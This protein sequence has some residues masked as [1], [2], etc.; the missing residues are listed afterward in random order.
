MFQYR[1]NALSNRRIDPSPANIIDL[2]ILTKEYETSYR[3]WAL[4]NNGTATEPA[5]PTSEELRLQFETLENYKSVSDALIYNSAK[6]KPLFGTAASPE[7]RATFKVIKNPAVNLSDSEI[8]TQVLRYINLFF[9]EGN[10]DFGDTFYFTEL[11]T[12]IQQ[13]L[14]PNISSIVIVPAGT[15][16]I[17]GSLH[18]IGSESDEILISVATVDNIEIIPSITAAQLGFSGTATITN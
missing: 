1:H 5:R 6:F 3:T 12:Y 14:A 15:G 7:L 18:E 16:Q 8:R 11:A 4:N 10:W 2:Y 17:Y 9:A 13:S